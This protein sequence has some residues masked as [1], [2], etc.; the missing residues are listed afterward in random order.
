MGGRSHPACTV[1][2]MVLALQPTTPTAATAQLPLVRSIVGDILEAWDRLKLAGRG[3]R[4]LEE[5]RAKLER[6]KPG[7]MERRLLEDVDRLTSQMEHY[8]GEL[9]RLGA[10]CPDIAAGVVVWL[11]ESPWGLVWIVWDPSRDRVDTWCAMTEERVPNL[12]QRHPIPEI[13]ETHDD[14][15]P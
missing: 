1:A 11:W 8:L 15:H 3:R 7:P 9:H 4:R 12:E 6:A 14:P 10:D 5:L 2:L 13:L